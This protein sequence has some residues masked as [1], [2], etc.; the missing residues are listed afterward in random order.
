MS[1]TYSDDVDAIAS[2]NAQIPGIAVAYGSTDLPNEMSAL[3][4]AMTI[5]APG[6]WTKFGS[7]EYVVRVY[8]QPTSNNTPSLAYQQ[9]LALI[10]A[11]LDAYQALSRV[12]DRPLMRYPHGHAKSA[13]GFGTSGFYYTQTWGKVPYYGFEIFLSLGP[14]TPA[15]P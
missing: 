9:C 1:S 15:V 13:R 2:I 6:D 12:N 3:P 5:V 8:V 7:D 11:F 10:Q 4:A 14:R